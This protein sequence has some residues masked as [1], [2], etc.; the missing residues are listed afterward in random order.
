MK[1]FNIELTDAEKIFKNSELLVKRPDDMSQAE[2]K[3]LRKLQSRA[4]H[5]VIHHAP[6]SRIASQMR[7][8]QMSDHMRQMLANALMRKFLKEEAERKEKEE[9]K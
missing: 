1:K 6:D 5:I 9:N 2:Y 4:L 7:P 8:K 3:A